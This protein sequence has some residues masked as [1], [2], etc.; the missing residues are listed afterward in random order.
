M[1]DRPLVTFDGQCGFCRLWVDYFKAITGDRVDY[2][3]S[4]E[5]AP[6]A[7]QFETFS[8]ASAVFELLRYDPGYRWLAWLYQRIPLFA[9]FSEWAYRTVA[10]HRPFFYWITRLLFGRHVLPLSYIRIEW[11]FIRALAAVYFIAFAS[12]AVQVRGLIGSRGIL[13]LGGYLQAL[14]ESFGTSRYWLVPTIFWLRHDDAFLVFVCVAGAAL[15]MVLLLGFAQRS[16]LALLFVLY[17]SLCSAG[18]DFMSFQWDM[19]LLEAGFLAVFLGSS[20]TMV[21]LMRWLL[22]RLMFLSGSVKLLSHDPAWRSLNAMRFHYWTQPLPTPAAWY[23]SQL[24]AWFQQDSTAM[25]LVTELVLPFLIFA[26]RRVRRFAAYGLLFLQ[27]LIL[28][29]GNYTFFNIL[30]IALCLF[31]FDD[32]RLPKW[33]FPKR[34][35]HTR[36]RVAVAVLALIA[37]LSGSQLMGTFLGYSPPLTSGLVRLAAPFGIVNTYGLF[38]VMTTQRPEIIVQGSN[39]GTNWLDYSFRYKPGDLRRPPPWV[40]PYQPRLDWQMWF[41]AL[42][43]WRSNPWFANFMV[44]LL[45]G[46]PDVTGL[47]EKSPFGSR[48][49]KYVR[50]LVFNYRF[51]DFAERRATG[52]WWHRELR[53][54]Y[55]PRISLADVR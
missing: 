5:P 36:P 29:T 20:R 40:A 19:L 31:L 45:D 46:S 35:P 39:D 43:N 23:V 50:A 9:A 27:V 30:A 16:V 37:I 3:A 24:P 41:A 11:L 48:P 32:A 7:V 21:W 34:I 55:F 25:V 42:S 17:V 26:P 51:T 1:P 44:R 2:Q 10:A 38:A 52:E 22:F 15:A 6:R 49:P 54:L 12:F 28:I 53:G 47:L 33:N 14:S 18:Q 8:G 13:P 4:N